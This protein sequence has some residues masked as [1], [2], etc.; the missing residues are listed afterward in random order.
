[1][2]TVAALAP[3]ITGSFPAVGAEWP[4]LSLSAG[5]AACCVPACLAAK[6]ACPWESS[7]AQIH[8]TLPQLEGCAH[9]PPAPAAPRAWCGGRSAQESRERPCRWAPDDRFL[10]VRGGGAF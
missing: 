3:T 8:T 2:R 5:A 10:P 7:K 9:R 6:Q 4:L 1:M